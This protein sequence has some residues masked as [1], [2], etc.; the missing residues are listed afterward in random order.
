MDLLE[1]HRLVAGGAKPGF[2]PFNL[3]GF[4]ASAA[5]AQPGSEYPMAPPFDPS[6]VVQPPP[7]LQLH[8]PP[9]PAEMQIFGLME[10]GGRS[11]RW[12]RQETLTLLEVRSRL[13]S[14]FREAAQK[15]PL[16]DEVSRIMAEEHGYQRSGRKC[17]EKLENL[18]KYYKKTKEGKAGRQDGKHYRFFRQLEA[19]YEKEERGTDC[20]DADQNPNFSGGNR[21]VDNINATATST[22]L[23]P[24]FQL[25]SICLLSNCSTDSDGS[26]SSSDEEEES[27][28]AAKEF[29]GGQ[30]SR[31]IE[32]QEAWMERMLRALEEAEAARVSRKEEQRQREAE[33]QRTEAKRWASERAWTEARDAAIMRA[34]EKISRRRRSTADD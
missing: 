5:P 22:N 4:S 28:R 30:I 7:P 34:L 18:Y 20:R 26:S 16:W 6:A 3:P 10:S 8:P 19:L 9:P 27:D 1:L 25:P 24:N 31:F 11:G 17:R 14:R 33:R 23:P 2:D 32:A 29:I 21:V 13:D 12:P 15:G